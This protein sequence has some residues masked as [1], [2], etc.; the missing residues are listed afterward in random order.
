[1]F[2]LSPERNNV[3]GHFAVAQSAANGRFL[4][5]SNRSAS[6]PAKRVWRPAGSKRQSSIGQTA[7]PVTGTPETQS[8]Y[9]SRGVQASQQSNRPAPKGGVQVRSERRVETCR[10]L[11]GR[12]LPRFVYPVT[13][14]SVPAVAAFRPPV[15]C[16]V[17]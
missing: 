11:G 8:A 2:P 16:V 6:R 14:T 1:M 5:R 7:N 4:K 10:P 15:L 3:F 9:P 17:P 13:R 12:R